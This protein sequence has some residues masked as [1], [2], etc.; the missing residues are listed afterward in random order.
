LEFLATRDPAAAVPDLYAVVSS[1][2]VT[3]K[4]KAIRLLG[5]IKTAESTETLLILFESLNR[6]ALPKAVTL[7]LLQAATINAGD[8]LPQLVESYRTKQMSVGTKIAE[9]NECLEGGNVDRGR[10]IFFGE[11]AAS[12]RRCHKI[13]GNGTDVGPDL[14][15]V[16]QDRDRSYLLEALIDPNAKIAKGFE[17][18]I[19]VDTD[20]RIHSGIIKEENDTDVRLVTP[21]ATLITVG[22][23]DIDEQ[24][25]GQ[26][27]MPADTVK[28][29]N[30]EQ[31]RDLVEFLSSLKPDN[32]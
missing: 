26:S 24:I 10:Q 11:T 8:T 4:Q 23:K 20:G 32:H 13:D 25:K 3:A 15:A 19:I 27:G 28:D 5:E 18:T 7:D 9:W 30:R 21:Q 1:G 16:G 2:S 12:C 22:K 14:S 17:T 31:V 29:L 6:N